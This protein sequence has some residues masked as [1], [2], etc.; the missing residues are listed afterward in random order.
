MVRPTLMDLSPVEIKHDPF[1]ISL[2]KSNR[3]CNVLSPKLYVP[4]S[5]RDIS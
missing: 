4:K 1:M 5:K 2:D 3:S